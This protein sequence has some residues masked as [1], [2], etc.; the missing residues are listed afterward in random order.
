MVTT[1]KNII[2]AIKIATSSL[3]TIVLFIPAV[4]ICIIILILYIPGAY[5]IE[6]IFGED[7]LSYIDD[8]EW[9]RK[10]QSK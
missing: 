9:L 3:I 4:L 6:K 8:C 2:N 10:H 1:I 7:D 5:I